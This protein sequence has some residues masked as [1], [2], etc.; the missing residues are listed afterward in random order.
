VSD[1]DTDLL[2]SFVRLLR[3]LDCPR[4]PPVLGPMAE[5]EVLWRLINGPHKG[6]GDGSPDRISGQPDLANRLYE[7]MR[8]RH[9][10]KSC[11][12][13]ADNTD[14]RLALTHVSSVSG[15]LP[16]RFSTTLVTLTKLSR[17]S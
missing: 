13:A 6:R 1:A 12:E 14:S 9:L 10:A 2:E 3:L 4:D 11:Y 17:P 5:R 16:V 15:L 8:N 7:H